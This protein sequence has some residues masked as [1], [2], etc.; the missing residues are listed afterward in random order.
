M[1]GETSAER[2]VVLVVE[3][4]DPMRAAIAEF[5]G[6]EFE[7]IAVADCAEAERCLGSR[8]FAAIVC[9]HMMPGEQGLVF[10]E[11][12]ARLQPEASRI[13]FTGYMNPELISRS[14]AVAGLSACLLK[15]LSM[16]ELMKAVRKAVAAGGAG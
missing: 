2:P 12:A 14:V 11:R 9:D 8:Q 7:V 5:I 4:D 3:D 10:L 13:L 15:P 16:E 6:R 1:S